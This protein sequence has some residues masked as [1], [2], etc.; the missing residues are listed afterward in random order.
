M[1]GRGVRG[2]AAA[3]VALF[4]MLAVAPAA[5]AAPRAGER[6]DGKSAT[7]QRIFLSVSDDGRRL[8]R[9]TFAVSTNCTDGQ[10][11]LQG[12]IQKGETP[13]AIDAAGSF[14]HQSRVRR[15]FYSTSSGRVDGRFR[16][17][18]SGTFDATGDSVTGTIESTF[19]S[20]GF[21]CSSGP[22]A[23]TI[24][25]DGTPQ[26]PFRDSV[27]ATGLYTAAGKGVAAKLR[28]L[29]PGRELVR[30]EITYRAR[31]R[32]GGNLRSGRV[33]L[34]YLL[35][36]NGRRSI[37]GVATFRIRQDNVSVRV[38]F[39][40]SLRFFKRGAHKVSGTWS[41]RAA[42]SSRGRQ[43]DTC[44]LKKSFKGA[45]RSGPA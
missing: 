26:A 42:V 45:F 44:R 9:Y 24:Y 7:G 30:A 40:L 25:R 28:T 23:F 33:F 32:S 15:G 29:A 21:D 2:S 4:L 8:D 1:R 36:D 27:M 10:R 22:V 19:E 20:D 39:R 18:F 38:R 35:S 17:T 16:T 31:C 41:I 5:L 12:T 14:S 6:Y 43:I 34:N 3:A 13:T 11:R 37:P